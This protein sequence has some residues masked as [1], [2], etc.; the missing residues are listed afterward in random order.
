MMY[1]LSLRR[2]KISAV[3]WRFI[4]FGRFIS[5]TSFA[6]TFQYD[7]LRWSFRW[8][9]GYVVRTVSKD[10]ETLTYWGGAVED[11]K[12]FVSREY[13]RPD[14]HCTVPPSRNPH[15]VIAVAFI[16]T[17]WVRS[18]D[19]YPYSSARVERSSPRARLKS[20]PLPIA[21]DQV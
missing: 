21:F 18:Y 12:V 17:A 13:G 7:R 2:L 15:G 9:V 20:S 4:P 10:C 1:A 8:W 5:F 6:S 16:F 19:W 14:C 3:S 11:E